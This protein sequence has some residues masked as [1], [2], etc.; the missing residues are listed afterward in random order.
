M[1]RIT[2]I[3]DAGPDAGLGHLSRSSA[4][5]AALIERSAHVQAFGLGLDEPTERY[6]VRWALAPASYGPAAAIVLD[7][8]H[9]DRAFRESLRAVAPLVAFS[10]PDHPA[11]EADLCIGSRPSSGPRCL[12]GPRYACLGPP[13]W[14]V[15]HHDPPAEVRR[16]LVATGGGDVAEV[17]VALASALRTRLPAVAVALVR[18]PSSAHDAPEGVELIPAPS[19][20]DR[21]LLASDLVV[22]SAGQTLLEALTIG[23]PAVALAVA[24]N[25]R[26]QLEMLAGAGAAF[27]V[28]TADAAVQAAVQLVGDLDARRRL[29]TAARELVDGRGA[30]RVADAVLELAQGASPE[31]GLRLRTVAA[32]DSELLLR[33]RNDPETRRFSFTT[34]EITQAEHEM[35]LDARLRDPNTLFWIAMH[36]R[37]PVGQVRLTRSEREAEIHI[38]VAPTSRGRGYGRAILEGAAAA[39]RERWPT[40]KT[41]LARIDSDNDASIRAFEAAGFRSTAEAEGRLLLVLDGPAADAAG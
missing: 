8:Y 24:D 10:D 11:D 16:V 33:W 1:V 2:L 31:N 4:L 22:C 37:D 34:H 40:V 19:S 17:G 32:S 27:A 38:A 36:D 25:Q 41:I 6:G 28:A 39:C 13:Y 12:S 29:S 23:V 18:G 21:A 15:A 35:W 5:A 14:R 7:S 20:L 9:A 3:A 30:L 26:A